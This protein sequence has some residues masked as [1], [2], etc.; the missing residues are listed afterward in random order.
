[1]IRGCESA[2]VYEGVRRREGGMERRERDGE[3]MER[4]RE[5]AK[6]AGREAGREGGKEERD[7]ERKRETER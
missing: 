3:G 1:M 7:G 6:E 2:S 5:G 4:G